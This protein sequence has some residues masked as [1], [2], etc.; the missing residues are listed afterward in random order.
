MYNQMNELIIYRVKEDSFLM[1]MGKAMT[2]DTE[3]VRQRSLIFASIKRLLDMA[4]Q[5]GWNHNLWHCALCAHLLMDENSYTLS[6]E[7]QKQT[8]KGSIQAFLQHDME[9]FYSLFH[10]DF[11]P[12]SDRLQI[13]C[14]EIISDYQAIA[15]REEMMD[16]TMGK[17]I[18]KVA[19]RLALAPDAQGMMEILDDF[20]ET[21]GTGCFAFHKAF[22]IKEDGD[23]CKFVAIRNYPEMT[24]DHIIGYEEQKQELMMNTEAFLQGKQANNVLLYGESGTGK[25]T[26]IKAL[27]NHYYKDGIRLIEIH[28]HQ[29]HMLQDVIQQIKTRNYGFIIYM[30]DLSFEEDET[31]YK[32]LKAVMEGGLEVRPDHMLIYATS[33]RRHLIKETWHDRSDV[34]EDQD[35]HISE[36]MSEKLSLVA[37]FGISIYYGRPTPKEYQHIVKELAKREQLAGYDEATLWQLANAWELR[38]GGGSGRC[39]RQLIDYLCAQTGADKE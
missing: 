30:D 12:I 29:F 33:N 3:D 27:G 35:L 32:Y 1:Q 8:L 13:H 23:G 24:L 9:I 25:S 38:H 22:R 28:K 36:T 2:E 14:F 34:N 5:Y 37:R 18:M 11:K 39:A 21:Y 31:E 4:T 10:Y 6:K 20:Y 19:K 15:K 7:R 17:M 26:S 16:E